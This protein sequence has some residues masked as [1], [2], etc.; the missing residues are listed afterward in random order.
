MEEANRRRQ[1]A[2]EKQQEEVAVYAK[3]K[4]ELAE[5]VVQH[6]YLDVKSVKSYGLKQVNGNLLVG[7]YSITKNDNGTLAKEIKV[8]PIYITQRR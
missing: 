1:E 5:E 8:A 4:F 7:V 3:E 2:K 6:K